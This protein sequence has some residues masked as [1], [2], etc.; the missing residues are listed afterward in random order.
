MSVTPLLFMQTGA[1]GKTIN[2]THTHTQYL[3]TCVYG[4]DTS[5]QS[6]LKK[7][8]NHTYEYIK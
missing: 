1:V 4:I 6:H 2:E 8:K 3:M 7:I 5:G